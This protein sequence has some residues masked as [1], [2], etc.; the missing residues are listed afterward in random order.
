MTPQI[1]FCCYK[2]INTPYGSAQG[3]PARA[4]APRGAT[5]SLWDLAPG[6]LP[7]PQSP[8]LAKG[9]M[10]PFKHTR[11]AACQVQTPGGCSA[12]GSRDEAGD[13]AAVWAFVFCPLQPGEGLRAAGGRGP[14]VQSMGSLPWCDP[15]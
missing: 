11:D 14:C 2:F 1:G 7:E 12:T 15:S 10:R 9:V 13:G 8:P 3:E 5:C 4:P 6:T